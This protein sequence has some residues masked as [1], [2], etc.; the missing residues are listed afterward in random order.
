MSSLSYLWDL[1]PSKYSW[2]FF[3]SISKLVSQDHLRDLSFF[4]EALTDPKEV[5]GLSLVLM[6][7]N[8]L[9]KI[10]VLG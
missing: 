5:L 8:L 1:S 3:L 6:E 4:G 10:D 2:E 9:G 7:A